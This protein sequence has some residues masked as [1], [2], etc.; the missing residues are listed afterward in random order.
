MKAV[1]I[2]QTFF[3]VTSNLLAAE[4]KDVDFQ[5]RRAK[6]SSDPSPFG[7]FLEHRGDLVARPEDCACS[8]S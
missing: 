2:A 8:R 3:G 5:P 7:L 4:S 6:R 1:K